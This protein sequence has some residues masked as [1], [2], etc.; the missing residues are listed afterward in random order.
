MK[1]PHI[2]GI[3]THDD[4]KSCAD[5]REGIGEA[6]TGVHAGTV[7]SRE[8]RF[9][10]VPTSLSETEGHTD[11]TAIARCRRTP[12]GRRPVARME[13]FCART[14]R[15]FACPSEMA[16]GPQREVRWT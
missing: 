16:G 5:P 6:L 11:G 10:G 8:I 13:P 3:T 7:L 14:G 9:V 2:E 15:S 12:R 4:P 1:E